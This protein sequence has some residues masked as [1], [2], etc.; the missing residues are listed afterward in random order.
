M[1]RWERRGKGVGIQKLMM[2]SHQ[3]DASEEPFMYPITSI[4]MVTPAQVCTQLCLDEHDLLDMVNHGKLAAYDIGGE[5]RF[6]A[7]DV[8]TAIALLAVA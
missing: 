5:I 7:I 8:V 6:K 1:L 3:P 2:V 4:D